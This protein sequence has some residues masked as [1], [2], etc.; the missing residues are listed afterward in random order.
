MSRPLFSDDA[1]HWR[2]E[3]IDQ[4]IGV[5]RQKLLRLAFSVGLSGQVHVDGDPQAAVSE[6]LRLARLGAQAELTARAAGS[7][8]VRVLVRDT[9]AH[10]RQEVT[11]RDA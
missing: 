3:E 7:T 2:I 1:A 8:T 9:A 5:H 11:G 6:L 10:W 4:L